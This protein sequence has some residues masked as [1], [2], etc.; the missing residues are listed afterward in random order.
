[1]DAPAL[2]HHVSEVITAADLELLGRGQELVNL[3]RDGVVD[4]QVLAGRS[5]RLER[6]AHRNSSPSVKYAQVR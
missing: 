5:P 3:G 2:S 6:I 4:V 1:M